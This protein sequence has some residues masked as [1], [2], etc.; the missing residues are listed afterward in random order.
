MSILY[1]DGNDDYICHC[2]ICDGVS[3]E[4]LDF[5]DEM[6]DEDYAKLDPAILHRAQL[7]AAYAVYSEIPDDED[8]DDLDD[9]LL[10][11][12]T[13]RHSGRYP[14]GSGENPQRNKDIL[15]RIKE[16]QEAGITSELDIAKA[17]GMSTGELRAAKSNA[18]SLLKAENQLHVRDL[19]DA[20][21]SISAI[22]RETGLP[23]T[24][25]RN[26]L[27]PVLI[28]RNNK[29]SNIAKVLKDSL[30]VNEMID[31]GAGVE[32]ELNISDTKLAAA[33]SMLKDEGYEVRNIQV[34]QASNPNQ[35]TTVKVLL[36]PDNPY[37][38]GEI[39]KNLDKIG[40]VTEYS[41]DGNG[42]G[43]TSLNMYYPKSVD[44]KRIQI[45]YADEGGILKDGVIELRPGVEDI[46]LGKSSYAQVRIAVDGTHYLK[47]MAMYADDLPEGVDIRVNSNKP[48][49]TP[50][51]KVFKT[52]KN[53]PDNPFGAAI[54]KKGQRLYLDEN[55][56]EQL[57]VINKVREEGEWSEWSRTLAAQMLSKQPTELIERQ[58]TL[59]KEQKRAEFDEICA[60][61]NPTV[62]RRL[63]ESFA[64]DCDSGAV[65]LKAISLPG[66]TT[67]VLLPVNSL[68]PNEIF[69]PG[70]DNGTQLALVRYPHGGTFEIPILTVNNKNPEGVKSIGLHAPDAVGIPPAA[71][72]QL[73]GADFDGDTAI[74]IP[75]NTANGV[76]IQN[77]PYLETLKNFNPDE[78][79]PERPGMKYMTEDYK[80]IEMGKITNLIMDMT[81]QGAP[82]D[83]VGRAVRYSMVVIDAFKH[84]YDYKLAYQKEGIAELAKKWQGKV[85]GGSFTLITKAKSPTDNPVRKQQSSITTQNTDPATGK[86]IDLFTNETITVTETSK[87]ISKLSKEY[88][89]LRKNKD[90]DENERM[91]KMD[92]LKAQ[93]DALRPYRNEGDVL[94]VK[95]RMEKVPKMS[96]TEDARDLISPIRH[97]AEILYADYANSLKALANEARKEYLATPRLEYSPT[98][99]KTYAEEVNSL[100][101]KLNESLKNAPRERQAQI[102]ASYVLKS[103]LED[104]PYMT[105]DDEKKIRT[106]AV[107]MGRDRFNATR[108][109]VEITDK[110]WDAIQ[111]GAIH[112]TTLANI[113]NN[114]DLDSVRE[115]ATPRSNS[116]EI[117][118]AKLVRMQALLSQKTVDGKAKYSLSEI[119][120]AIGVSTSTIEK[121]KAQSV[122]TE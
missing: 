60:L 105:E 4:E 21:N 37:K 3:Q 76:K 84:K 32:R 113:L 29:T 93:I 1:D 47:G 94:A 28:E 10:H 16:L 19:Y 57:S 26:L 61:T 89:K 51:E 100:K 77:R 108:T 54:T 25:I 101:S 58:L 88:N 114:A 67:K 66:Q 85:N 13:P 107:A 11:Y 18:K 7:A 115:R 71:A 112:D 116:N 98:A 102:Y 43:L 69:A 103:K 46:S 39:Y 52:M 79:Y 104:N 111:A 2:P 56:D 117:P 65:H 55:G 82:E 6:T 81:M 27:N 49:G 41:Q 35:K 74:V 68:Q 23:E 9:E 63:L 122:R 31:V 42:E 24:T 75:T 12:G 78:E 14:W 120:E 48:S 72:R 90:M 33:L 118:N 91:Q 97:P 34:P 95:T 44:S 30:E 40:T 59:T 20:G 5:E 109:K 45:V 36:K 119:A 80:G 70:Y 92:E 96:I 62:K 106:A 86:R 15:G 8:S 73:S 17:L 53:D 87:E 50:P 99:A 121:Y 22:H 110:E 64:S 38:K 83:E